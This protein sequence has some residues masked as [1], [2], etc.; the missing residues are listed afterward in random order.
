MFVTGSI[1]G[2]IFCPSFTP[3]YTSGQALYPPF[4]A[5][6]VWQ[7]ESIIRKQ[8]QSNPSTHL[9]DVYAL[10]RDHQVAS[11]QMLSPCEDLPWL[12]D[13]YRRDVCCITSVPFEMIEG[14]GMGHETV[15]KTIASG[16]LFST[17]MHEIC[18]HLQGLLKQ[19]YREIYKKDS[20]VEFLLVPM[21]RLEVE[22]IADFKILF[23]IGALTPDMSIRLSRILL[24][25]EP[26][27]KKRKSKEDAKEETPVKPADAVR[28][29]WDNKGQTGG[30]IQG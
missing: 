7:R 18:R 11:Q 12:L 20:N 25:E 21:P 28:E 15:R 5:H 22:T 1:V 10:P 27:A 29:A 24:G 9:P 6:N 8:F 17:N 19:A 2:C 4:E 16:R 3:P 23:E 26:G 13:K 14:R 30:G